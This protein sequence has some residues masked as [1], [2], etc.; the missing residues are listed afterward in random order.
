MSLTIIVKSAGWGVSNN[1]S[2]SG[3]PVKLTKEMIEEADRIFIMENYMKDELKKI[4]GGE[5][6]IPE[7]I[8]CLDIP[9]RF[10]L[11]MDE[12]GRDISTEEALEYVKNHTINC[13]ACLVLEHAQE[14][15]LFFHE[16]KWGSFHK[17]QFLTYKKA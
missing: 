15:F 3:A 4:Y 7:K 14:L 11:Y 17:K 8:T 10:Y 13:M 9:D 12:D 6:D 2:Y 16:L 5:Q 1:D